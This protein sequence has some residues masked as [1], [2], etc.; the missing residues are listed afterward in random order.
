LVQTV[1]P[2]GAPMKM[3]PSVG[4]LLVACALLGNADAGDAHLRPARLLQRGSSASVAHIAPTDS[5]AQPAH[6]EAAVPTEDNGR[7]TAIMARLHQ[8]RAYLTVKKVLRAP[9]H[10]VSFKRDGPDADG[11][12]DSL[13]AYLAL[14]A[15]V[16]IWVIVATV[17]AY[18]YNKQ[19]TIPAKDPEMELDVES[20]KDFKHGVFTCASA[21]EI[22]LCACLCPAIRWAR[23]LSLMGLLG[24]W[25]AF[26]AFIGLDFVA[27]VSAEGGIFLHLALAVMLTYYRQDLRKA[28]DMKRQGGITYAEDCLLY[29]CCLCCTVTQEARHI[30]DAFKAGHHA[31][32][33]KEMEVAPAQQA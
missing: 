21:P 20:F 2:L 26:G 29:L 17:V 7:L 33:A 25:V 5:V 31:A 23:N 14:V 10:V 28:F 12:L 15:S 30:E 1:A 3:P 4:V 19:T 27:G 18:F 6:V 24:F 16:F 11:V 13:I 8:T 9:H 22:T 32:K